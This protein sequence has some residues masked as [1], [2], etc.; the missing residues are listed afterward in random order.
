MNEDIITAGILFVISL[1]VFILSIRSFCEKGFLLNNA[2]IYASKKERAEMDKKPY[3]RQTAVIFL[4]M[5]IVFFLIGLAILLDA[6][7]ITYVA[8]ADIVII[9]IYA[10]VSGIA[11]EKQKKQR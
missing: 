3:Y 5:G 11:I 7:W 6:G 1:F 2:Y 9:V 10:V 8:E 4:L